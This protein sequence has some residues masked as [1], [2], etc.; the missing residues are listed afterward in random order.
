MNH[1]VETMEMDGCRTVNLQGMKMQEAVERLLTAVPQSDT[2]E[3]VNGETYGPE[4]IAPDACVRRVLYCVTI[5]PEVESYFR[6]G[7]YDLLVAHHPFRPQDAIPN[8]VLHTALDCCS[9][10]LN[11]Q[12]RDLLQIQD[13]R[14]ITGNLGWFGRIR[15]IPFQQLRDRVRAFAGGIDGQVYSRKKLRKELVD[16]VAICAGLGG[17]IAEEAAATGADVFITGE[18]TQSADALGSPA[19]IETGHT[20]SERVGVDFIRQI[21]GPGVEVDV[22]PLGIDYYG[23]ETATPAGTGTAKS[24]TSEEHKSSAEPDR[25]T[26]DLTIK[27]GYIL[28][29][30]DGKEQLAL[31]DTGCPFTASS[32]EPLVLFGENVSRNAGFGGLSLDELSG[33]LGVRVEHIVGMDVLGRYPWLLD[34]QGR[35]VTIFRKPQEFGGT[36][37]PAWQGQ[38]GHVLLEFEVGGEKKTANLDSGAPLQ[39]K[40]LGH[41][42]GRPVREQEDFSPLISDYFT[43]PVYRVPI[44]FAGETFEAEFGVLPSKLR[45]FLDLI[46]VEWVLGSDV[47]K[48]HPIYWDLPNGRLHV[49]NSAAPKGDGLIPTHQGGATKKLNA[50]TEVSSTVQEER[51]GGPVQLVATRIETPIIKLLD[52]ALEGLEHHPCG[53]SFEQLKEKSPFPVKDTDYPR[54]P[55]GYPAEHPCS[56]GGSIWVPDIGNPELMTSCLLHETGHCLLH[57]PD[58]PDP[59]LED[60]VLAEVRETGNTNLLFQSVME[61]E[62]CA[63]AYL[64]AHMLSLPDPHNETFLSHWNGDIETF[65]RES[66]A[67]C[68]TAANQIAASYRPATLPFTEP[69]TYRFNPHRD[70]VLITADGHWLM[71]DTGADL[72][73]GNTAKFQFGG[74]TFP[75]VHNYFGFTAEGL[76]RFVGH[77][78]DYLVGLRVLEKFPFVLDW[79]KKEIT[80]YPPGRQFR[81]GTVVL[82]SRGFGGLLLHFPFRFNGKPVD[83]IIDTGAPISYMP[84]VEG[85]PDGTADDFYPGY[86]TWTTRLYRNRVRFGN[87]T[88]DVRFGIVP[89][90]CVLKYA[91]P[92]LCGA[93]FFKSGPVGFDISRN[94]MHLFTKAR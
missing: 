49:L 63:A 44:K 28:M 8:V 65:E 25:M 90:G 22:A 40:P 3:R 76:T 2:W 73:V 37:V 94:R 85:T 9:G 41:G 61:G 80:F 14:H 35:K 11:D 66:L 16:T 42:A 68:V 51:H 48:R 10:G 84:E 13:A 52:G 38:Q 26:F 91:T 6:K 18:L 30:V 71:L 34:W 24:E 1:T 89:D 53:L 46:G 75:C 45:K 72:T 39:F 59:D 54:T 17:W 70:H 55:D 20:R 57:Y 86:G 62:A 83:G 64:A 4:H 58:G 7:G 60:P 56:D 69:V 5:T 92:W 31:L 93:D 87:R 19:V 33:Y 15:P 67:R 43:T 32:G 23:G 88:F 50:E 74:M 79:G 77:Q 27:D 47:L 21:L 36:V 78:V 29:K 82:M 12:W 81:G